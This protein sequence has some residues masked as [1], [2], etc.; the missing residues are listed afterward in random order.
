MPC[1]S[2]VSCTR[3]KKYRELLG[4]TFFAHLSSE[5]SVGGVLD[6]SGIDK[7]LERSVKGVEL[8]TLDDRV[9]DGFLSPCCLSILSKP[10]ASSVSKSSS[11]Y[12]TGS[13]VVT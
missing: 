11:S 9:D 6:M 7:D 3:C 12:G 13:G 10:D 5:C 1:V 2:L 8:K 4:G